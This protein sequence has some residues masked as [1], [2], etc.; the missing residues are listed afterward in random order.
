RPRGEAEVFGGRRRD[1]FMK[2]EAIVLAGAR[3]DGKLGEVSECAYEAMI[4]VADRPMVDYVVD[5]LNGAG[6]VMR[7]VVVGPRELASSYEGAAGVEW[8]ESRSSM[9]E[10]IQVGIEYLEPKGPVLIVTSDIPL[11]TAEAI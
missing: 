1:A 10:N 8:V 4:P 2:V 3:N 6:S 11:V 5:A 7:T 9:V